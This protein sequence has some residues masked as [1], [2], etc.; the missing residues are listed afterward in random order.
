M[1]NATVRYNACCNAML[2]SGNPDS[3]SLMLGGAVVLLVCG[4]IR[5]DSLLA[6][7]GLFGQA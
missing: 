4:F 6:R 3:L 1:F 5:Q 7:H 2:F